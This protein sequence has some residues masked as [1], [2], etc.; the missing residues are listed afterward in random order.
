LT[1]KKSKKNTDNLAMETSSDEDYPEED[2]EDQQEKAMK[3]YETI[4]NDMIKEQ[5]MQKWLSCLL[6]TNN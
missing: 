4:V 5:P 3:K 2:S 1:R 6:R